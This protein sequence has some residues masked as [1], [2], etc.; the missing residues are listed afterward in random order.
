MYY[1]K[2][3]MR[4]G[5]E[6]SVNGAK[7]PIFLGDKTQTLLYI[8][9]LIR[10]KMQQPLYLHELYRNSNGSRSVY[11]REKTYKWLEQIFYAI[12]G[13]TSIFD[14][15][16]NPKRGNQSQPRTGHDFHQA[17]CA[18]LSKFKEA[19]SDHLASA[20]DCCILQTAD[21]EKGDSFYSFNCRPEDIILDETAENLKRAFEN[22]Y[23]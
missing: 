3:T 9:A 13:K 4:Y 14:E 1:K 7:V 18:I 12:F 16:A 5:V 10:F 19:L 21:D 15:W 20:L 23:K 8:A 2:L 11:K 17:K 6:I 22:I